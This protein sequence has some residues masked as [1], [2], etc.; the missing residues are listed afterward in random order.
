M[1][2][3]ARGHRGRSSRGSSS[4]DATAGFPDA[5]AVNRTAVVPMIRG[6]VGIRRAAPADV[7]ARNSLPTMTEISMDLQLA[8]KTAIVTGSTAGI[9]FAIASL[10]AG[11][12]S[13]VV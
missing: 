2:R 3:R 7:A 6:R 13:H 9:G 8:G 12:G 10:L 4:A 11:E 1:Y 5:W